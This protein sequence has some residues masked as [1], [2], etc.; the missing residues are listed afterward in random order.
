[1]LFSR[2][3]LVLGTTVAVRQPQFPKPGSTGATTWPPKNMKDWSA[4]YLP[5]EVLES[6]ELTDDPHAHALFYAFSHMGHVLAAD[7]AKPKDGRDVP[8]H[9]RRHGR[10]LSGKTIAENYCEKLNINENTAPVFGDT[11]PSKPC[12]EGTENCPSKK[13]EAYTGSIFTLGNKAKDLNDGAGKLE[14]FVAWGWS[15]GPDIGE[16]YY[17]NSNTDYWMATCFHATYKK[18]FFVNEDKADYA[19]EG[20]SGAVTCK[21]C[22][23]DASAEVEV[24]FNYVYNSLTEVTDYE[25][26][27]N[28]GG[29]LDY[30]LDLA[31]KTPSFQLSTV[32]TTTLPEMSEV[33]FNVYAGVDVA[34]S[35]EGDLGIKGNMFFTQ[36]SVEVSA[37][38]DTNIDAWAKKEED[39]AF[40]AGWEASVSYEPLSI[41]TTLPAFDTSGSNDISVEMKP[42]F[43]ITITASIGSALT[44]KILKL[45]ASV[46]VNVA[47][48]IEARMRDDQ[49][50]TTYMADTELTYEVQALGYSIF[51]GG[52]QKLSP[53]L[54]GD[55]DFC[56]K[57]T[58]GSFTSQRGV[59][60]SGG[61]GGGGD[62]DELDDGAIA[63]IVITVLLVVL[64][65][66]A[67]AAYVM[68][69]AI[70]A[71]F[72][73]P[74]DVRAQAT[75]LQH[76]DVESDK[77]APTMRDSLK[78]K[79]NTAVA[80][81]TVVRDGAAAKATVMRDSLQ[82][83][84]K[85]APAD[86]PA[87]E[88]ATELQEVDDEKS[89]A[90]T[91]EL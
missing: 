9:G 8:T 85:R 13:T 53:F 58:V 61:G 44:D 32:H 86:E 25:I 83:K 42:T 70:Q 31:M 27:T 30:N 34:V 6:A 20:T 19:L 54:E 18:G 17:A 88:Q 26:I 80:K 71:K 39:S 15:N 47:Y 63:G 28:L 68:R 35:G 16:D 11:K 14:Y 1:M 12:T 87:D 57:N 46:T 56:I 81:A 64:C 2:A 48:E 43:P 72:M 75:E 79:F 67:A 50:K 76:H 23:V 52:D 40:D 55:G 65:A 36:G 73:A 59:A 60:V 84:F 7:E 45:E 41:K 89:D 90:W 51:E 5:A 66:T 37:S 78:D 3:A 91:P 10:R 24:A 29:G 49:C 33:K 77:E 22:Y 21:E 38:L 62:D 74:D 69:D 82:K 4:Q